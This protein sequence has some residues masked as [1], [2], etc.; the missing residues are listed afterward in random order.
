[1]EH[2]AKEIFKA[3]HEGLWLDIDYQNITFEK[4]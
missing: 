3:I 2:Y 4:V 1:M